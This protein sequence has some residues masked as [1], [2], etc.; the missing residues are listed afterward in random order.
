RGVPIWM[1]AL[2]DA[3]VRRAAR[4]GDA[5]VMPPGNRLAQLVAQRRMLDEVRAAAGLPPV[6][7][8][9]LRREAFVAD[10]DERAWQLFAP[11]LRH[12]YGKVY[13]PLHP[14]YPE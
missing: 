5:W 11:G 13:R 10:T 7:E 14:T 6:T 4:A 1:G 9:P 3:G 2:E 8:Q 12:E